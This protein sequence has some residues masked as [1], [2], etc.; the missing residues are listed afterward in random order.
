MGFPN[1]TN[2]LESTNRTTTRKDENMFSQIDPVSSKVENIIRATSFKTCQRT[3]S[4]LDTHFETDV[5]PFKVM[6]K[7][8]LDKSGSNDNCSFENIFLVM[9]DV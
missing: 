9:Y 3:S 4:G 2:A 5:K 1:T 6:W 7:Y 8:I